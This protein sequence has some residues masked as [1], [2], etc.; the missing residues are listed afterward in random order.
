MSAKGCGWLPVLTGSMAPL[1][2]P[3]DSVLVTRT[4]VD[5]LHSGDII[6]FRRGDNIIVHRVLHSRRHEG[7]TCFHEKGDATY[8][9][10]SVQGEDIIGKITALKRGGKTVGFNTPI[11]RFTSTCFGLWSD[12]AVKTISVFRS[13]TQRPLKKFGTLLERSFLVFSNIFIRPCFLVWSISGLQEKKTP[14][15]G[16]S[17]RSEQR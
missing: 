7:A 4:N 11:G 3:G 17:C 15:P 14:A 9:S 1:I 13:S 8:F 6:A 12:I 2:R 16:I 5:K 10:R